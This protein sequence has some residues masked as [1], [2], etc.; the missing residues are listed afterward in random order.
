MATALHIASRLHLTPLLDIQHPPFAKF[1]ED[2]V[3]RSLFKEWCSSPLTDRYMLE[4]L[5]AS[6][7]ET[8]VDGHQVYRLPSIGFHFGRLHGA[9]LS[10]QTGSVRRDVTAL[11]SFCN[12]DAARGYSV[13]REYYFID[14]R[15]DECKYTDVQLIERLQE[16]ERESVEFHD[17]ENTWYY[18]LGCILGELSGQLFPAA[19]Q[20][21]SQWET[22]RRYWAAQAS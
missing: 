18:A 8:D 9:V 19:S 11:A 7:R 5:R 12:D 16:L 6:L 14:A 13:G 3:Y 17:E 20:E 21:Y 4:N 22:D 15:P 2:G 10:P 1:Y